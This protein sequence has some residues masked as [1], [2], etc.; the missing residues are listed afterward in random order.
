M[1]MFLLPGYFGVGAVFYA[2]P[3]SDIM[4]CAAASTTFIMLSGKVL[5]DNR[6]LF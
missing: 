5:K 2:E 6:R 3:I 4:A 1:G